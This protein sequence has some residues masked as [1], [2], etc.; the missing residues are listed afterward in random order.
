MT[1]KP[2][3]RPP[4]LAQIDPGRFESTERIAGF[5]AYEL[6]SDPSRSPQRGHPW[7]L[8]ARAHRRFS[9]TWHRNTEDARRAARDDYEK[10][11][12]DGS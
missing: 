3:N 8:T 1:V 4:H 2:D 10:G 5:P 11:P 7:R 9:R 12:G 6:V